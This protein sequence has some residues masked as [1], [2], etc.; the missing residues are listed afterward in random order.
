MVFWCINCIAQLW[1]AYL[2]AFEIQVRLKISALNLQDIDTIN[3]QTISEKQKW[4]FFYLTLGHPVHRPSFHLTVRH[5]VHTFPSINYGITLVI[6][7]HNFREVRVRISQGLQYGKT[8]LLQRLLP[9][10]SLQCCRCQ[11][12]TGYRSETVLR[13]ADAFQWELL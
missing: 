8:T 6:L 11:A 1:S 4:P 10:C 9:S 5:L 2:S 13:Q 7:I 12:Q 3:S